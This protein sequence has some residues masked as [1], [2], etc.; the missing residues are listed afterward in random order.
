MQTRTIAARILT[1]VI[2]DRQSLS[3]VLADELNRITDNKDSA[4]IQELCYGVLRWFLPLD[5]IFHQLVDK[6]LRKKDTDIKMLLL[7]GIYQLE[8]LSTPDHAAVFATVEACKDLG[9]PWASR[10]IN[11]VL[12]RY[13]RDRVQLMNRLESNSEAKY[14]H[15]QWLLAMFQE[16]WPKHWETIVEANNRHPPMYLRVNRQQTTRTCYNDLLHKTGIEAGITPYAEEGLLLRQAVSVN[17]L[18]GFEDGLVSVQDLSAQLAVELLDLA[19]GQRILDACAAPGGKTSHIL[20]VG[21]ALNEV[22]AV[23]HDSQRIEKLHDNL[24]RL[25]LRAT[26]HTADAC[27]PDAWW[28]GRMFDRILIDAPCSATG[29]IRRHPDIKLLRRESDI[30]S[31]VE[32]Q[33]KLLCALWPALKQG[34]MLL[35][36][37]C[38]VLMQENRKQIERFTAGHE[39]CHINPINALW[40]YTTPFGTQILTGQ[41]NMD[42][43]FYARLE[44]S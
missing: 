28:D 27:T 13:L 23:D 8:Y 22:V 12:R 24:Q 20:E 39:D 18:P 10:L 5:F 30:R 31:M 34:G 11:A 43:F 32:K 14:A 35:Y 29:V 41:D 9:K 16:D 40:G 37:T 3:T 19:R 25:K 33:Y 17:R 1:R 44:K 2:R 6:D 7:S 26:V 15:P 42:G 21:E 38:S 36:V 4:F